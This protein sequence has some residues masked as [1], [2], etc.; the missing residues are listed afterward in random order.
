M[1]PYRGKTSLEDALREV[2]HRLEDQRDEY[3]DLNRQ[4]RF[5]LNQLKHTVDKELMVPDLKKTYNQRYYAKHKDRILKQR[6]KREVRRKQGGMSLEEK[7]MAGT[8]I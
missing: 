6:K 3:R 7:M 4:T 8:L 1:R 2:F 5:L